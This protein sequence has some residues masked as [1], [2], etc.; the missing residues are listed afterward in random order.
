[1]LPQIRAS[2]GLFGAIVW[3][4]G[5]WRGVRLG[6]AS[7]PGEMTQGGEHLLPM[8]HQAVPYLYEGKSQDL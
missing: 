2:L 3:V 5:R 7:V 4:W 6:P 8:D 1:M